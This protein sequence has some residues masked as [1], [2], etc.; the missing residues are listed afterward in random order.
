MTPLIVHKP[1]DRVDK[2]WGNRQRGITVGRHLLVLIIW[3]CLQYVMLKCGTQI[4]TQKGAERAVEAVDAV[5]AVRTSR[6]LIEPQ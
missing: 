6:M 5:H 1:T 2:I 4:G 3:D